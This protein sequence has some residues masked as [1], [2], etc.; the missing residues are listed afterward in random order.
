[1]IK[2]FSIDPKGNTRV[3][4]IASKKDT[5]YIHGFGLSEKYIILMAWPLFIFNHGL[6]ILWGQC[7]KGFSIWTIHS[8]VSIDG[9][10][11][12]PTEPVRFY[13]V[14]RKTMKHV[15]TYESNRAFFCYHVV[16]AFDTPDGI[17]IDCLL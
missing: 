14:D 16:N 1:M 13:I 7:F 15:A 12:R 5:S 10:E 2:V 11:W 9:I 8:N 6:G 17:A 3:A 4:K